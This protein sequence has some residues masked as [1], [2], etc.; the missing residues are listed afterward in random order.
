MSTRPS[1]GRA[2]LSLAS[3]L[4]L[5][6]IALAFLA[7]AGLAAAE[8][9]IPPGVSPEAQEFYRQLP[10]RRAGASI[11]SHAASLIDANGEITDAKTRE[12]LQKFL[13]GF[14]AHVRHRQGG[15]SGAAS[16]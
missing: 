5:A 13:A 8:I 6:S 1:A 7:L 4:A 9:P 15:G 16:P 11:V 14:V 3:S 10:P 2:R 12:A